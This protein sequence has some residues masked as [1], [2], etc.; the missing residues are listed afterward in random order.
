[1]RAKHHRPRRSDRA[2]IPMRLNCRNDAKTASTTTLQQ[3]I[4]AE[5][6]IIR[7]ND[8]MVRI[9]ARRAR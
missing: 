4:T 9:A 3:R 1:M 7:L 2:A 8:A 5:A 6:R